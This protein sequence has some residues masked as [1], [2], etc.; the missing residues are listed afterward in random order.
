MC[1]SAGAGQEV[2][3]AEPGGQDEGDG[4]HGGG[5]VQAVSVPRGGEECGPHPQVGGEEPRVHRQL[6]GALRP[7]RGL[8]KGPVHH[9]SLILLSV[10]S[11]KSLMRFT[12]L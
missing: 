1:L 11:I 8:G 6:P 4:A 12:V 3:P 5:E 7:R 10:V 2:P 9:P